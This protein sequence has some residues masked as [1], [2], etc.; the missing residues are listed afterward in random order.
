MFWILNTHMCAHTH[1]HTDWRENSDRLNSATILDILVPWEAQDESDNP[2]LNPLMEPQGK[3]R[4]V[5]SPTMVSGGREM[6][7]PDPTLPATPG[8]QGLAGPLRGGS[9]AGLNL[10]AD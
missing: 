2:K 1:T 4:S 6:P 7:R 3:G 10:V 5:R 9:P 8:E